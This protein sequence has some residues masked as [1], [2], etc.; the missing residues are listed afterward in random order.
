MKKARIHPSLLR[1]KQRVTVNGRRDAA[2]EGMKRRR[3]NMV[4]KRKLES[5]ERIQP[6]RVASFFDKEVM[7][8]AIAF[9]EKKGGR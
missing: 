7:S 3:C 4:L 6:R 2:K 5:R 9:G 1:K 8:Y